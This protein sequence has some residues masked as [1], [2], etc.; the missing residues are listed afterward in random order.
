[1]DRHG[2]SGYSEPGLDDKDETEKLHVSGGG[3]GGKA[4]GNNKERSQMNPPNAFIIGCQMPAR[5]RDRP[6]DIGSGLQSS[7][8]AQQEGLQRKNN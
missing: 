8:T 1:M 2:M 5:D 7:A 4:E 6:Q 3:A